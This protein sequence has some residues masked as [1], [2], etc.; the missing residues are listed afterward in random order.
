MGYDDVAATAELGQIALFAGGFLAAACLEEWILRGYIFSTLREQL[1]WVHAAGVA[2]L[3]FVLLSLAN[4]D[5]EAAGLVNT[6]LLGLLLGAMRELTGSL[7][8]GVFFHAAW[9]TINF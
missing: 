8:P 9:N 1:S 7:W 5:I 6:F 2:A 4:T 3:L